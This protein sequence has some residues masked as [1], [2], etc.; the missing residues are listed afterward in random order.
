MDRKS[1]E[2]D[3]RV[4]NMME[5]T[6]E[7]KGLPPRNEVH[8][9][10]KKYKFK[11]KYP[12]VRFLALFFILLPL[13]FLSFTYYLDQ[14]KII[15]PTTKVE[16]KSV[17][18]IDY[19]DKTASVNPIE[20]KEESHE[21]ET[22]SIIEEPEAEGTNQEQDKISNE[23]LKQKEAAHPTEQK[24]SN[25]AQHEYEIKYHRVKANETLYRISMT[26]YKSRD[27]EE[28]LKQWNGLK[29]QQIYEG[30]ILEIP[31]KITQTK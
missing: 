31:I 17:E 1:G 21:S 2:K 19:A 20:T 8:K 13:T 25:D 15:S 4:E 28:I 6:E 7:R 24:T 10:K 30:Q 9:E 29:S 22:E 23:Q 16:N 18:E 3:D 14:R 26:Y 12:I 5:K 27:G 11:I